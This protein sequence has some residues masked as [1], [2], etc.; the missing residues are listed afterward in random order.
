M[1]GK[2]AF[3]WFPTELTTLTLTGSRDVRDATVAGAGGFL[4]GNFGLQLDQ[5][6]LRN[7]ILTARLGYGRDDYEG[8]DREDKRAS[9]YLGAN[10][11]LNRNLGFTLA[12][13]YLKQE[14]EGAAPGA[15][16]EAN[17]VSLSSSLQF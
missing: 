5:E 2:A 4:S 6:L 16:F 13:D 17:R 8:I 3:E 7:L 14:S 15:N 11:L 12:Y 9:G 10:Y 1:T